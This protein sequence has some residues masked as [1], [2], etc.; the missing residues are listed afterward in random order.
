[1]D[2]TAL[3]TQSMKIGMPLA[4]VRSPTHAEPSLAQCES[5]A[6]THMDAFL[7]HCVTRTVLNQPNHMALV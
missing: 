2:S 5:L 7:T 4:S 6:H 3:A 1:M